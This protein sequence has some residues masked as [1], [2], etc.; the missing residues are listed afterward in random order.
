ML[1]RIWNTWKK[2]ARKIGNVQARV[3]LFVF[4]FTLYMPFSLGVRAFSDPLRLK[5]KQ[6]H[7]F[8]LPRGREDNSAE[9]VE[10]LR[11]QF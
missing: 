9:S 7:P 6:A 5:K 4:Y 8:W 1:R 3:I 11:R 2:W 10:T